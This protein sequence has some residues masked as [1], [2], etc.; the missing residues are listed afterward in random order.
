MSA[1]GP[2]G[3]WSEGGVVLCVSSTGVVHQ[4]AEEDEIQVGEFP[5]WWHSACGYLISRSVFAVD[6]RTYEPRRGE[7]LCRRCFPKGSL[8]R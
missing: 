2:A 5:D 8:P 3:D 6:G 7:R 1:L 4:V